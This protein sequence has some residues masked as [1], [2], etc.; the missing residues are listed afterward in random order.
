MFCGLLRGSLKNDL[1]VKVACN[2]KF[3]RGKSDE[4]FENFCHFSLGE[5][6]LLGEIFP[7][8]AFSDKVNFCS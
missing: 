2:N 1:H 8:K 5:L 4:V 6:F 7:D 3:R